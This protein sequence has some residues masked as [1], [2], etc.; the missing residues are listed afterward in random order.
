MAKAMILAAGFG[1]RLRPLTD[2]L[3][4]PL[5]WVGDRP[6][7]GHVAARLVAAGIDEIVVNTH[8]RATAFSA[9]L[10]ARV[11][12]QIVISTE[13]EILGTGGGVANAAGLLG[14]GDVVVW[15]G[16]ILVDLDVGALL[17]AHRFPGGAGASAGEAGKRGESAERAAGAGTSGRDGGRGATIA[18][19]RRAKGEGTVGRGQDG[20]VVR[21]RGEVFGEEEVGG[22]F[23]GIYVLGEALRRRLPVPGCL[24]GDGLLPW[25]R[26]GGT[27]ATFVVDAVWDDIGSVASYLRANARWLAATGKPAFV[28]EG[29]SVAAGVDVTGSVIGAGATVRGEGRLDGCVVWPGAQATAP[30]V[31]T[32]VTTEGREAGLSTPGNTSRR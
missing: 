25:L 23:L 24:V 26:D 6:A 20:R 13:A 14:G 31:S 18:V 1:T 30:L 10:L 5:V 8:H 15:N 3:P 9:E 29:A 32:V 19:A 22:D 2:E 4:K 11:P 16:D 12:G 21:L 28:G 7:L 17:A 27:V